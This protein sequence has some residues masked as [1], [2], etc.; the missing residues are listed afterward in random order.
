M[1]A[2]A[3]LVSTGKPK[4]GGAIYRAPLGTTLPT[5]ATDEL[6]VAFNNLGYISEDGL[7]NSNNIESN[8]V[9]AWGGDTVLSMQ[10]GKQDKYKFKLIESLNAE[11][12]KTVY[13]DENVTVGLDNEIAIKANSKDMK[14]ACWIV[15]MIMKGNRKRR[16][17][18]PDSK[19]SEIGDVVYKDNEPI[20]YDL[21]ITCVPDTEGN[22][23]YEYIK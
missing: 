14:E 20:G 7:T 9:K 16:I 22:T 21:T 3:E 6:D 19:V 8:E 10:T 15:E 12:L 11:V 2:N 23:H 17:V 18:I 1:S 13:G 4:I 5:N